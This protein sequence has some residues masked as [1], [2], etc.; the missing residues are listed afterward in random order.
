MGNRVCKNAPRLVFSFTAKK[1]EVQFLQ[2]LYKVDQKKG[3][4]FGKPVFC[5]GCARL[6]IL[7]LQKCPLARVS[8]RRKKSSVK[9]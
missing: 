9:F 6:Q 5:R 1:F 7:C 2:A 4:V 3:V 8:I